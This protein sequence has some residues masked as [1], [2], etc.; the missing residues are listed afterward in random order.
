MGIW[1][2]RNKE[3]VLLK[4]EEIARFYTLSAHFETR[5]SSSNGRGVYNATR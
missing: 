1:Q 5:Q 4:L 3:N 2:Q